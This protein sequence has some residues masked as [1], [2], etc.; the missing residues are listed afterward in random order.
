MSKL[1]VSLEAVEACKLLAKQLEDEYATLLDYNLILKHQFQENM[2]GLGRHTNSISALIDNLNQNPNLNRSVKKASLK[3]R[4]V[5]AII[6]NHIENNLYDSVSH[7]SSRTTVSP[8]SPQE[9]YLA[10]VTARIYAHQNQKMREPQNK[11]IWQ[12]NVF[13]PDMNETPTK[14]NP[15]NQSFGEITTRLHEK[16]GIQFSGIP[17]SDGIADFSSIAVAQVKIF[18]IVSA[19]YPNMLS[20]FDSID[21]RKVFADRKM[22]FELADHFAAAHQLPIPNLPNGYSSKEL[23]KWRENNH[24]TWEESPLHG[25]LL[26]PAEIH[27]NIPHTGLVAIETKA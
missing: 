7:A 19:Y 12:G 5:A 2:D 9:I 23:K 14:F 13:I 11:G 4:Q 1:S 24:F 26:V 8:E 25:Y 10:S 17:F 3:L 27:N 15:Y 16:F 6:N 20:D 21:Y 22:N 18:D